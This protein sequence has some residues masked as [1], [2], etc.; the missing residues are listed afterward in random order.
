M[1]NFNLIA[2]LPEP[3]FHIF[4]H[5]H[6]LSYED[7]PNY[8]LLRFCLKQLFKCSGESENVPFDWEVR[9]MNVPPRSMPVPVPNSQ[10][11]QKN[12][13]LLVNL[14]PGNFLNESE[15]ISD[16]RVGG[17]PTRPISMFTSQED[18]TGNFY[19]HTPSTN[20][21]TTGAASGAL[22][23]HFGTSP[24]S[25][26]YEE[27]QRRFT[28]GSIPVG[29]YTSKFASSSPT[30]QGLVVIAGSYEEQPKKTR[31]QRKL[32][33]PAS[34]ISPTDGEYFLE[35]QME[36]DGPSFLASPPTSPES[37][38]Y[39]NETKNNPMYQRQPFLQYTPHPPTLPPKSGIVTGSRF[40]KIFT[41]QN[42]QQNNSGKPPTQPNPTSN[43]TV[44]SNDPPNSPNQKN[45]YQTNQGPQQYFAFP[46]ALGYGYQQSTFNIEQ[47][48]QQ[49]QQQAHK[50]HQAYLEQQHSQ[51]SQQLQF[52][53]SY[54][55]ARYK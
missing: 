18:Q 46:S 26:S 34:P 31:I 23:T 48:Q 51:Q 36:L 19:G 27:I 13:N 12:E 29:S 53:R 43:Y 40:R 54:N 1:T 25:Q 50:A 32:S 52:A 8:N 6:S 39:Q 47:N 35:E 2:G 15:S 7:R 49:Q 42:T 22:T 41:Q 9:T 21:F 28:S 37:P 24:V 3:V 10:S 5:I 11:F 16:G 20:M 14:T 45:N 30:G 4:S 17:K 44:S 33:L 55:Q 38:Q